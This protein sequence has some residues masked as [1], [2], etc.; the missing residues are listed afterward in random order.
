[1]IRIKHFLIILLL[2]VLLYAQDKDYSK[3]LGYIDFGDL[4]Q[5]ENND[6]ITE[7]YLDESLLG[8]VSK[9]SQDEDAKF[10]SKL[11][12]IKVNV[13]QI[14]PQNQKSVQN[15]INDIDKMLMSKKWNRIVR[16]KKNGEIA[17]VYIMQDAN[18]KI[19]GLVVT[20][21]EEKGE[22]AFINIVGQ[23]DFED[24]N[25]LGDQF[26]IPSLGNGKGDKK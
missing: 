21:I 13:F 20:T 7:V 8:M 9:M 25:K 2:P 5:F 23:I 15:K 11:K 3:E 26:N 18:K 10:I 19:A 4:S 17:N 6:N 22:A 12:L 14:D 1:M 24:M 16:S